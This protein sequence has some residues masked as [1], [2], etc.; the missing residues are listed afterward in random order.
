LVS[1]IRTVIAVMVAIE[2]S[3]GVAGFLKGKQDDL[4]VARAVGIQLVEYA[5]V[6]NTKESNMTRIPPF[7]ILD[8]AKDPH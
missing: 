5:Q 6:Y 1:C 4:M 3:N 7:M 8:L 2:T